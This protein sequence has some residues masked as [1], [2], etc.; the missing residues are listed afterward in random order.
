MTVPAVGSSSSRDN[1]R[2]FDRCFAGTPLNELLPLLTVDV[3]G[4]DGELNEAPFLWEF[5]GGQLG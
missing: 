5:V 4:E 3:C 1:E 2:D